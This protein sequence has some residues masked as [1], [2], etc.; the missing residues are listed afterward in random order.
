[1]AQA[2]NY[3]PKRHLKLVSHDEGNPKLG[4]TTSTLTDHSISRQLFIPD[5]QIDNMR[6]SIA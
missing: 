5:A 4:K 2:I 1:M 3:S 6:A